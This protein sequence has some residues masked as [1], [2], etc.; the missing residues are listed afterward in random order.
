LRRLLVE[1]RQTRRIIGQLSQGEEL[2]QG[3][4]S[5][6]HDR[7]LRSGQI[8]V[9]GIL[10]E[11]SVC[12]HD[13][14]GRAMGQ[15]RVF[16]TPLQLVWASGLL[17]EEGGK[18]QLTL[19]VLASRQRDNGIE[20]LGGVCQAAKVLSCEFVID[21]FEDVLL[22]RE[23][24]RGTGLHPLSDA[25]AASAPAP[26]GAAAAAEPAAAASAPALAPAPASAPAVSFTAQ[27]EPPPSHKPSWADAVMA[28]VRAGSE[29]EETE[30]GEDEE[31]EDYRPVRPGDILDHQQFGRCV[32]Q[33]VD[34]DGDFVT[35]RLRNSR[36]VRLSLEV[37]RLRYQ[38][39]EDGHQVFAT[40]SAAAGE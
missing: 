10:D 36:L 13:R 28:S 25:F 9:S 6:C 40:N 24:D 23:L 31:H 37:L 3:L 4:L 22:R 30:E 27:S 1:S 35:V 38:G 21:A 15:A 14:A 32:V 16:R 19:S 20:L 34:S 12:H 11:L 26:A 8:Q 18:R 2:I 33:R 5:I 39:D 29:R 17:C 7:R